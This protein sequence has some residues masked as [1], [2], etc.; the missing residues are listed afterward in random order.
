[1]KMESTTNN[2]TALF[3]SAVLPDG[4]GGFTPCPELLTEEEAIRYLRLDTIK[5]KNPAATL[6]RYREAGLLRAV[7]ISKSVFYEVTELRRL[8]TQLKETNPR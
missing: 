4:N 1:M 7:Q 6:R 8:V 3:T 5:I 2:N